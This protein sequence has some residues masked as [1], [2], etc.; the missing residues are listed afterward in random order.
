MTTFCMTMNELGVKESFWQY[1][2]LIFVHNLVFKMR[3][4]GLGRNI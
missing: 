2:I 4:F 1:C 3:I